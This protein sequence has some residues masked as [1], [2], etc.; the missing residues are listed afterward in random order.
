MLF[1]RHP[2]PFKFSIKPRSDAA[3]ILI[4]KTELDA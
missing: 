2:L 3:R 1:V 4:E